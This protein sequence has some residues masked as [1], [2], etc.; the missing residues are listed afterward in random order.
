MNSEDAK[1]EENEGAEPKDVGEHGVHWRSKTIRKRS[2]GNFVTALRGLITRR[3]RRELRLLAPS[4]SL[5]RK[6]S[7]PRMTMKK[8]SQFHV[9]FR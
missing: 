6:S 2:S 7:T 3:E 8:S 9:S 1:D 4:P 5:G